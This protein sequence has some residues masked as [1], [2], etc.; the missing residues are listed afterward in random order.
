MLTREENERLTRVGPGK[1]MGNL[2]RRHW[3]PVAAK[4]VS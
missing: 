3:H 2:M 4:A 1:P